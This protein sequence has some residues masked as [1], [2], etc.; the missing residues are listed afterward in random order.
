[1]NLQTRSYRDGK[2][3][4]TVRKQFYIQESTTNEACHWSKSSLQIQNGI[5]TIKTSQSFYISPY[6]SIFIHPKQMTM[7]QKAYNELVAGASWKTCPAKYNI[8]TYAKSLKEL[9]I[10]TSLSMAIYGVGNGLRI[11]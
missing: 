6:I 4:I 5:I 9:K 11:W 3:P 8:N 2:N 7:A 10:K 1:M